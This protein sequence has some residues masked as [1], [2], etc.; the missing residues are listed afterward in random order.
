MT[1]FGLSSAAA[2]LFVLAGLCAPALVSAPALAQQAQKQAPPPADSTPAPEPDLKQMAL[3]EKQVQGVLA[4]EP[5]LDAITSKLPDDKP[6]D[7]KVI[8]QLDAVAKQHGFASYAEFNAVASNIDLLL[9]GFDPQT[10]KFVGFEAVVKSQIA[11]IQADSKI[12]A[13]DKKEALA[14]LN[15]SLSKIPKVEFPGNVEIVAKYYDKL[16]DALR[17]QE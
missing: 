4:A 8:A 5:D 16:N 2:G 6:P 3:T 1:R 14:E 9:D 15:G 11:Q 17:G 12:P 7:A 10:K 13:A